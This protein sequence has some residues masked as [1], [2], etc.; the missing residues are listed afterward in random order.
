[1]SQLKTLYDQLPGL[2]MFLSDVNAANPL[3][4]SNIIKP[5][6]RLPKTFIQKNNHGILNDGSQTYASSTDIW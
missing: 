2:R 3:W 4:D 6:C 1:M 5:R